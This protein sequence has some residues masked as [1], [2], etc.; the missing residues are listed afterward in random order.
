MVC[1][2]ALVLY[3]VMRMRLKA[4]RREESPT[5]LLE[6]LRRIQHQTARAQD[7]RKISGLTEISAVQKSLLCALKLAAPTPGAIQN[8]HL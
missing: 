7:G 3:R 6:Q 2:V 1:F 8:P 4:S 5:R